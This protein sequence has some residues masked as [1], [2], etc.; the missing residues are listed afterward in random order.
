MY[1]K[2]CYQ[3]AYTFA[4]P[5]NNLIYTL[6]LNKYHI[7]PTLIIFEKVFNNLLVFT[8]ESQMNS[9][10]HRDLLVV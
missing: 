9:L 3:S 8:T 7:G 6:I 10:S 5:F 4:K 2:A 1:V